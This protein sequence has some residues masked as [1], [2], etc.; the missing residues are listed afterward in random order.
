MTKNKIIISCILSLVLC[1]SLIA[2]GTY[3]LFTSDTETNISINSGT[4]EVV[5]NVENLKLYSLEKID[6]TTYT[7]TKV[8][9]T[10]EKTFITG[11]TATYNNGMLTLQK[12]VPGDSVSFDIVIKNNSNVAIQYRTLISDTTGSKLM[13]ALN[14]TVKGNKYYGAITEQ[15]T[16]IE[17]NADISSIPVT[18]ELPADADDEWQN[19]TV[20]FVIAIEAVQGNADTTQKPIVFNTDTAYNLSGIKANAAYGLFKATSGTVTIDGAGVAVADEAPNADNGGQHYAIA[21]WAKGGNFVINGGTFTQSIETA[22]E[23]FDLIYAQNGTITINGGTFKA[24]TPAWTLNCNDSAYKNGTANII[25][26]GGEFYEFDPADC[27]SEGTGTSFLADGYITVPEARADGTWYK[28]VKS[29]DY[30]FVETA[31]DLF[32]FAE[33]VDNGNTFEGKTVILNADIDLKN[34]SWNPIGQNGTY[35][36]GNFNGNNKKI[37]N[38]N[39]NSD[40][41]YAGLFASI[42]DLGHIESQY[43]KDLTLENATV[44]GK[45]W[46]GSLVGYIQ[47]ICPV[48]IE[49]V[50]VSNATVEGKRSGSIA[51]FAAGNEKITIKDC[52]VNKA[53]I[54]GTDSNGEY[55]G[56]QYSNIEAENNTSANVRLIDFYI[57]NAD[58]IFA[59]AESV[60]NGNSYNN[61]LVLLANN[62]DLENR[63][64]TPIGQTG[65]TQFMGTFDGQNNKI[66]NLKMNTTAHETEQYYSTGLFG[67]LNS[68]TVKNVTIDGA[69]IVSNKYTGAI[70]GYLEG[71]TLIENCKVYNANIQSIHADS[72]LACGDKA[73]AVVGYMNSSSAV[74]AC[75]AEEC[76][77][78]AGRD[79]GFIVGAGYTSKV[80]GCSA[81][82]VTI[83]PNSSDCT[84]ANLEGAVIGRLL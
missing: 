30:L 57:K 46:S 79:A 65:A 6:M 62:I 35:F 84:G 26:T 58:D 21:V 37:S 27:I 63:E 2:G 1:A 31:E 76:K 17:A 8:E 74:N 25:V 24:V 80:T 42:G 83:T 13:D 16:S 78:Y 5:A 68:A 55:L 40:T 33:M 77:V 32:A 49:N 45:K 14:V 54:I 19:K 11:G 50:T 81:L 36:L 22:D 15:W 10:N 75:Y 18:I 72:E 23:D 71:N 53:D 28:V 69:T 64:W 20:S 67:W 44:S 43:I 4:V 66:F 7:G 39:I 3:A 73:G 41:N 48:T 51:G 34:Q 61:K 12:M 9:R 56:Y 60:N 29:P 70:A 52:T 82:N 38:L 47:A 59:F